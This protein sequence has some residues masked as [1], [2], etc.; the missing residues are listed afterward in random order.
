MTTTET[1]T[2]P[3]EA[4]GNARHIPNLLEYI[5]MYDRVGDN[6]S[7]R[8]RNEY[9]RTLRKIRTRLFQAGNRF[10]PD[11]VE[12]YV[13]ARF[14]G[15]DITQ[16]TGRLWRSACAYWLGEEA[17]AL[18]HLGK[19]F[20]AHGKAYERIRALSTRTLPE[21]SSQSSSPRLKA[22]PKATL[23]LL[24]EYVS[25]H[26]R[27]TTASKLLRYLRA[28]L[29]LGLR[30]SE[31]FGGSGL[32]CAIYPD[33]PVDYKR[34]PDGAMLCTPMMVVANSKVSHGRANGESREL[35]LCGL[36]ATEEVHIRTFCN[37]VERFAE[38]FPPLTPPDE[39]ARRFYQKLNKTLAAALKAKNYQG[40]AITVYSARH[41]AVANAKGSGMSIEEIA[42][43]FGHGS[44]H[45]AQK[46]YGRKAAG[47]AKTRFR[48][49]PDSIA[50]VKNAPTPQAL[51]SPTSW[52]SELGNRLVDGP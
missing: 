28:N 19:D 1:T 6:L 38:R 8:S 26:P 47:W 12:N 45:T 23:E 11:S 29:L 46:H 49:S 16:S 9:A 51:P 33:G 44:V 42:A 35:L 14:E 30:P 41:Q 24:I 34:A 10:T 43:F 13:R 4:I 25:E 21:R 20:T 22:F 3:A 18:Y 5:N 48:P 37:D 31:W 40:G 17:Q 32:A 52:I 2:K 27:A 39:L 50:A 7:E 36:T 15:G